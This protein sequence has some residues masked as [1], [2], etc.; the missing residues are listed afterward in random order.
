MGSRPR[1]AG[2]EAMS[3]LLTILAIVFLLELI[4]GIFFSDW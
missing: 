4:L 2:R 1:R 3:T